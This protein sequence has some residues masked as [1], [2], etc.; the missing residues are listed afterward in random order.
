MWS[1]PNVTTDLAWRRRID[2]VL[3]ALGM[4][5]LDAGA[6]ARDRAQAAP[7]SRSRTVGTATQAGGGPTLVREGSWV[8][9]Y[10]TAGG[11]KPCQT[12][13]ERTSRSIERA[14]PSHV[15]V[16]VAVGIVPG[17]WRA[18]ALAIRQTSDRAAWLRRHRASRREG[19]S[20]P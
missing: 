17:I 20:S 7:P 6:G 4:V 16:I 10:V 14:V 3:R 11:C 13:R 15:G 8:R 19:D 5:A 2:A 12:V 9:I 1:T 18:F